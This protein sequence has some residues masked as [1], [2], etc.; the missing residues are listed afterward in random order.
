MAETLNTILP[1]IVPPNLPFLCI[2]HEGKSHLRKS[3]PI[4]LCGWR[5]PGV[6]FVIVHDKDS[7]DCFKLKEELVA[8]SKECKRSDTLVRIACAELESWFLGDLR[9]IEKAFTI[10]LGSIKNKAKF[11]K[12]DKLT[13][14]KEELKK[15]IPAYQQISGAKKISAYMDI[16]RN[17]SHSFNVFISGIKKITIY[18]GK[19]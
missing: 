13:N 17:Q 11:R 10:D 15:L 14:A 18:A 19:K 5:E 4:K 3:I 2:P 9:A 1:K 6:H 16:D 8:I 7:G 12:P